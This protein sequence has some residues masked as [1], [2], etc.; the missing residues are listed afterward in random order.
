MAV[1]SSASQIK[2]FTASVPAPV[3]LDTSNNLGSN[4]KRFRRQWEN[5]AVATRLNK[6]DPEFQ[7]AVFLATIGEDA[8]DIFE[9]FRFE[10]EDDDKNVNK[11]IEKFQEFCVG[12]TH[13]AY[14]AYQFH[15]RRQEI[16]ENMDAF[17]T[18]LRKLAKNCNFGQ[19]ED[20]MI[21][22]QI[23]VGIRDDSLRKKM[24]ED[25]K[26][27]LDKCLCLGRAHE[28]STHQAHAMTSQEQDDSLHVNRIPAV[29]RR[30]QPVNFHSKGNKKCSRCGKSPMHG[31]KDCPAKDAECRNCSAKGHYAVMCRSKKKV[32]N[33]DKENEEEETLGSI[34][35]CQDKDC[36]N[37]VKE[38]L[39][40]VTLQINEKSVK[41]R[42]DT[43]AD[44]SVV[45]RRLFK[46]NSPLIEK[47]NKKLLGPGKMEIKVVGKYTT[48]LKTEKTE[49]E[50]DLY[51]VENLQEPLLGRPA[52]EALHLIERVNSAQQEETP[53][54]KFPKLFTGLGKM[55][56]IYK[57]RLRDDAQPF[58]IAAPRRLPLPFKT[59]VKEELSRLEKEDII[60]PVTTPTDWCA[61]IV[62]V[63]KPN[64]KMRLCIDFTKLNE[65]VRRENYP[66]P[67]TD[68]LLAQLD[69]AKV[70]S[71]LDCNSGFHQIPLHPDSQ[72]LTTFIT[73]F[74]RYC[75]KRLPFGISSGPEVFQREMSRIL[76]GIPG[77]ICDIDDVLVF[78]K[79]QKE[80]DE[81]L[82]RVLQK[83]EAENI[84]LNE[85]CIFS[86]D[87]VTF[88]GHIIT[89][90]GIKVDPRK[91]DAISNFPKPQNVPELRRF[92]GMVNHVGKFI[93]NLADT[94]KPLRDL[95][96][97]ENE[98][99][100][101]HQQEDAFQ[102]LKVQLSSAPVLAHYDP[103]KETKISADASS[104][105]LGGV[106]LQKE[107][108]NWRPVFYASRS[109]TLTEQRYAQVEK[110]ALAST[111]CCEKFAD[112]LIGLRKFT[113]ETDHKPLL[114]LLK[115]KNLD[116]LTPR[117][118]RFRMRL[119]RFS[120]DVEYT[121]GKNIVIADTLSR[122][123]GNVPAQQDLEM[124][125]E[126]N[127]FI[128]S[129]VE[130]L[131]VS[132]KL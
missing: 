27:D 95:L 9:G 89:S 26:L 75:Y 77:V 50:Q 120:Y 43:G 35:E 122:A 18:A 101:S 62:A 110:E 84:T 33:I 71:K 114:S 28:T 116:E 6:E 78:G 65:S 46:K 12:E 1:S 88:L 124:E 105:G 82:K 70:F 4:W 20:R 51:I 45:P 37:S 19:Q 14:E 10:N 53:K 123:P 99:T 100:W 117:I 57:I 40:H 126:T 130:S 48:I 60:R 115:K 91:V 103:A 104:Y 108:Q 66:L 61:P 13:E 39:W 128:N 132:D 93:P 58:S 41:F 113:I 106:L 119:L 73:P 107:G 68:Q 36:V 15:C 102:K 72:E 38:D 118:Q 34:V 22:D 5:Y 111:W 76:E 127:Q 96:K 52:I 90:A 64:G 24:L 31:R 85:K 80:H 81:R 2:Q 109:L 55:K 8:L 42:V 69:G 92:L 11:I 17:V 23:I 21:R 25:K 125:K 98:W 3:K 16:S 56:A 63:L 67:T 30:N 131:P 32:H 59:K 54:S 7:K 79:D 87:T 94:S 112:F 29:K 86:S 74:G 121:P 97:E 47:T 129:L 49:T 83:M 44:V